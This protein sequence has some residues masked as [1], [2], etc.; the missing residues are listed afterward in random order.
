M[1]EGETVISI[2]G[3]RML[4][5]VLLLQVTWEARGNDVS[6][7]VQMLIPEE[8]SKSEAVRAIADTVAS[9]LDDLG[10]SLE[11][12]WQETVPLDSEARAA[13]A[14]WYLGDHRTLGVLW[15]VP[16]HGPPR[17]FSTPSPASTT[18]SSSC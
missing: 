14:R 9:Q 17:M 6:H 2:C 18:V 15:C 13:E 5:L 16:V 4:A 11:I 12:H 7:V 8:E 1:V 10:V 3:F